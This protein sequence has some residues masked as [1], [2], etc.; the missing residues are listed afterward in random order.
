M[1]VQPITRIAPLLLLLAVVAGGC[2]TAERKEIIYTINPDSSGTGRIIFHNLMSSEEEGND[3][4]LRDYQEIVGNYLKGTKFDDFFPELQNKQKRIFE[5]NGVLNGEVSFTF[6]HYEEVGLFRYNGQGPYM[7]HV[8]SKADYATEQF[9]SSNGDLYTPRLPVVFWPDTAT[10]F[11][12]VST[13]E[14]PSPESRSL[15]PLYKRIG[16]D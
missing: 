7:Y 1:T 16:T 11:R 14:K 10:V 4:S 6:S 8:G 5:E 2:L 9:E 12:I 13:I 3:V 15:L